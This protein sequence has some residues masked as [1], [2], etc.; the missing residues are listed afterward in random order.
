MIITA[1]EFAKF[2]HDNHCD[3]EAAL[4]DWCEPCLLNSIKNYDDS[5]NIV[6]CSDCKCSIRLVWGKSRSW[7]CEQCTQKRWNIR[8]AKIEAK[9]PWNV[10]KNWIKQR[11]ANK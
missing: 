4:T 6:E 3:H 9:Q 5:K 7:E 11:F 2:L 1:E 10:F 8:E